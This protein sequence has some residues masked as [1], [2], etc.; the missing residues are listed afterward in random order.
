M[1]CHLSTFPIAVQNAAGVTAGFSGPA[2]EGLGQELAPQGLRGAPPA[3]N[4][5]VERPYPSLI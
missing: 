1:D 4:L 5:P 3:P 2:Y